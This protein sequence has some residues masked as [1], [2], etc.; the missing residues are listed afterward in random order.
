MLFVNSNSGFGSLGL[1]VDTAS[2]SS[3]LVSI[4]PISQ[5]L[6]SNIGDC[7]DP[8][9]PTSPIQ[10]SFHHKWSTPSLMNY[11]MQQL[12]REL[13]QLQKDIV[14]LKSTSYTALPGQLLASKRVKHSNLFYKNL[15]NYNQKMAQYERFLDFMLERNSQLLASKS[16]NGIDLPCAYLPCAI[17]IHTISSYNKIPN[18]KLKVTHFHEGKRH[19]CPKLNHLEPLPLMNYKSF[20]LQIFLLEFK[21]RI[22]PSRKL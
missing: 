2:K 21:M 7:D 8:T 6:S 12:Q 11:V 13:T 17:D 18:P 5:Y 3:T 16:P 4:R 1:Q 14:D 9:H 15:E 20:L 19:Y 10:R 22:I